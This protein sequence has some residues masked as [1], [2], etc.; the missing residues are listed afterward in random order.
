[1]QK[2]DDIPPAKR[3]FP[4]EGKVQRRRRQAP[5]PVNLDNLF[6]LFTRKTI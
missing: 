6:D 1:L 2:D 5:P 3:P 4:W